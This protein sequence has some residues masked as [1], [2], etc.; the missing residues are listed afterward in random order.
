MKLS[1][2]SCIIRKS[3]LSH[4]LHFFKDQKLSLLSLGESSC[5]CR[6]T[7]SDRSQCLTVR[8]VCDALVGRA[9]RAA[10]F[11]LTLYNKG[12]WPSLTAAIWLLRFRPSRSLLRSSTPPYWTSTTSPWWGQTSRSSGICGVYYEMFEGNKVTRF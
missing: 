4:S 11:V 8:H 5:C 12:T 7:V 3:C 1:L 10:A 6:I 2:K 9:E